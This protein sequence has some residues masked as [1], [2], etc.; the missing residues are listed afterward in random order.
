[1][2]RYLKRKDIDVDKYDFCVENSIQ[3]RVYAFSWYLDIVADNWD[4]LVL[5]DYEVVMPIPVKRK[6]GLAYVAQPIFCQQLGVFSQR[7]LDKN[8]IDSF[9]KQLIDKYKKILYQFNA[10]NSMVLNQDSYQK[11][12]NFILPLNTT[13]E[14]LRKDYRK[15][16]KSRINQV[17]KKNFMI[18]DCTSKEIIDLAKT[19]YTHINLNNKDYQTLSKII[20]TSSEL[21]RGFLVGVYDDKRLLG[22]SFFLKDSKRITYL[23]SVSSSE[24]KK[25]NVNS[26]IL[27]KVI[28]EYAKTD[29]VLDF[30][31]SMISGIAS[32]FRSF[33]AKNE[34][35]YC[36]RKKY[37]STV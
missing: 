3:S 29:F 6:L 16:R 25:H 36:L 12:D 13:Y 23:F 2:I 8:L 18:S 7:T 5:N 27:D 32:F 22:A 19:F 1:M 4:V 20:S 28:K 35:Y 33:G 30:E 34:A 26:L 9:C 24:G 37:F 15:D 17:Q 14:N 21:D 31:G 10:E 11:R